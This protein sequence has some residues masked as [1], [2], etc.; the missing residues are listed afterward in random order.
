MYYILPKC[1]VI[2]NSRV[3]SMATA[4]AIMQKFYP[5]EGLN[6]ARDFYN[7]VPVSDKSFGKVFVLIRDPIERFLSAVSCLEI[8]LD[9]AIKGLGNGLE[10]NEHFAPQ[11]KFIFDRAYK[12]PEQISEFCAAIGL[13]ELPL[14][15]ESNRKPVLTEEQLG[16]L[17]DFYVEDMRLYGSI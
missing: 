16:F 12:F 8:D 1:S 4:Q 10:L 13:A 5:C 6:D 2:R 11:N 17:Q 7:A 14:V 3:A 15:N 9:V